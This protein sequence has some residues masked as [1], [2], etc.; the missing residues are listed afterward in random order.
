MSNEQL[1]MS[2]GEKMRARAVTM[3]KEQRTKNKGKSDL[4]KVDSG[5]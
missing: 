2:N 4:S 5:E 1:T 3:S